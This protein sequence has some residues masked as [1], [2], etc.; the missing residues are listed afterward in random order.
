MIQ[1]G[2]IPPLTTPA[3]LS[4]VPAKVTDEVVVTRSKKL[5]VV[6]PGM[7][8]VPAALVKMEST[9]RS[10]RARVPR[11]SVALP[12]PA[13]TTCRMPPLRTVKLPMAS[14][15]CAPVTPLKRKVPPLRSRAPWS[16]QRPSPPPT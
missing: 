6:V 10:A 9:P 14:K 12:E 2:A 5:V 13:R 4:V 16:S 7:P 11:F 15:A 8:S 1:A 3:P